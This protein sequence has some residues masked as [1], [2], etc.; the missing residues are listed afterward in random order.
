MKLFNASNLDSGIKQ[1]KQSIDTLENQ[2]QDLR[3]QIDYFTGLDDNFTGKSGKSI[4]MFYQEVHI[5]FILLFEQ[6]IRQYKAALNVAE[7]LFFLF[8]PADDGYIEESFLETEVEQGLKKVAE[9]THQLV[10]DVNDALGS[11]RDIMS[12]KHLTD[13]NFYM[14]VQRA[15]RFTQRTI[16]QLHQTDHGRAQ[17]LTDTETDLQL[18]QKYITEI[19]SM[20]QSKDVTISNYT[21][22]KFATNATYKEVLSEIE[23][24]A[25]Y[26]LDEL[27]GTSPY[28][29]N[30]YVEARY[31]GPNA[32]LD[33]LMK[34]R[35]RDSIED[36]IEAANI[37]SELTDT[38]ITK[39]EFESLEERLVDMVE[40]KNGVDS[41]EKYYLYDDGLIVK[42]SSG[43]YEFV[44]SI[45]GRD[46]TNGKITYD[47]SEYDKKFVGNMWMLSKN[48]TTG[49]DAAGA[50]IAYNEAIKSGKIKP[51]VPQTVDINLEQIEA[52]K[53]GYNYWTGEKI[54][55]VTK[56]SII[57]GGV[58]SSFSGFRG[59]RV[60]IN[61][62]AP[63]RTI[64]VPKKDVPKIKEK[65]KGVEGNGV[66]NKGNG[67]NKSV[68]G[69]K[70][71][72]GAENPVFGQDWNNYFKDKYGN[73][74]VQW[75]PTS[76]DDIIANPERLYGSTKSEIKSTL[77]PNWVEGIYGRNGSGWKFTN[78]DGSVF[79]HGGG[80]VHKGSYY[81]FSNGK[82]KKVKVYKIEDGYVPTVDDKGT[83]I[84]ID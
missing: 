22:R 70:I 72:S 21:F 33:M 71:D 35:Y 10:E 64:K 60:N 17:D 77:G 73:G 34:N 24:N 74:N 2:L 38:K 79:Y 28:L 9:I 63:P 5:P 62:S 29:P 54:S 43:T 68:S 20:F 3:K 65:V 83:A 48:G 41:V 40:I 59:G 82:T 31:P 12:I 84:Q 11:I 50:T 42:V 1:V 78:P 16:N 37:I 27:Y 30:T 4:R 49:Q 52:A 69:A 32:H 19:R 23:Q 47:F 56:Y 13:E 26:T 67:N 51:E 53:E 58:F 39:E 25:H 36:R 18:L 8:E 76:F 57:V 6:T 81:G 55:D 15:K 45:P 66:G 61:T 44:Q 7:K 75:K 14:D 80:G 46:T